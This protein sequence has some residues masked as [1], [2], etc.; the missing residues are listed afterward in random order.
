MT[1]TTAAGVD[2]RTAAR[3]GCTRSLL[4]HGDIT[5]V[6]WLQELVAAA[7]E[8]D[9]DRY[10]GGGE[11]EALERE[12]AELLEMQAAMYMPCGVMA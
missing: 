5:P 1:T 10:G 12:L 4:G 3:R 7:S 6:A 9:L 8:P 2:R 11:V